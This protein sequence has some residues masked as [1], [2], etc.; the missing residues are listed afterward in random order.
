MSQIHIDEWC[1]LFIY[2]LPSLTCWAFGT[3]VILAL[4][5]LGRRFTRYRLN[6]AMIWGVI[7]V[8]IVS[9]LTYFVVTART[10]FAI[11]L[12]DT[13]DDKLAEAAYRNL[14]DVSLTRAVSLA[15]N[16]HLEGNVR[17]YA[18][19]RIADLLSSADEHTKSSVLDR[20]ANSPPFQTD[21]F[22]TNQLTCGFFVPGYAEGPFNVSEIIVRRL[23]TVK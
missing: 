10:A 1:A 21:F 2:Y 23:R 13:E 3:T 6:S 15:I 17:F 5:C 22:R 18:S 16:E 14:F 20:V 19:C 12:L 4:L 9:W 7:A 8:S 11:T